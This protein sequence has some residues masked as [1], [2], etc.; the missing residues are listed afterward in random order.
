MRFSGHETF[1]CKEQWLYKGVQL[2]DNHKDESIFKAESAIYK[3]GVGKNMVRS[4]HYWLKS[5]ALI[6]DDDKFL[7]YSNYFFLNQK[8]DPYLENPSTLYILQYL[9]CSKQYASLYSLI[10]KDYFSDKTNNELTELQI[11]SF[12]KRIL[13]ERN[14]NKF[15]ENT[16][17][18]DFK[19][20]VKS[21]VSPKKNLK[22]IEDDFS[23]P[24]LGLKLISDTSRKNDLNQTIYRVNKTVRRDLSEFAFGFCI[25]DYFENQSSIDFSDIANSIGSFLCLSIEGLEEVTE[26]LCQNE[27]RFTFKSDAG[28]KQLQIKKADLYFKEEILNQIYKNKA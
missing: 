28:V 14:I 20:F 7:P 3:L 2:I 17:K 6:D 5:F 8:Y 4:V 25:L 15:T 1:H 27:K 26:R 18:S 21:Y 22:T 16:L 19:V 12:L 23:A 9:L 13:S 24:L 10:F 11:I